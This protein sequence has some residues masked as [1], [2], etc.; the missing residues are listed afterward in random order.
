MFIGARVVFDTTEAEGYVFGTTLA[1]FFR[2][3]FA[4]NRRGTKDLWPR[5]LVPGR[6]EQVLLKKW[7]CGPD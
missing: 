1:P 3:A 5:R 6:M 2:I 4:R 7:R